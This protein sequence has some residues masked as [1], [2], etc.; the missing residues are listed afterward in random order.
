MSQHSTEDLWT[1]PSSWCPSSQWWHC[2]PD[3]PDS[4][5]H[6]V[7]ALVVALVHALQPEVVVETGTATG[8]TALAIGRALA[9]NQHG[10][11]WTVEIDP[12]AA[13]T[14]TAAVDY[15]PVTVECIDSLAWEPPEPIDFAWIDSGTAQVR[16]G[17]IARWRG[18]FRPGAI[19]AVHDTAPNMGREALHAA[20]DDLFCELGWHY[21]SLRTPRGVTLAQVP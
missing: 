10:H 16:A 3:D 15:L 14:A 9:V 12:T 20:L 5:E 4:A 8:Q 13:A 2:D 18:K 11:L 1:P 19:V 21:L 17:E 6:E 7:T